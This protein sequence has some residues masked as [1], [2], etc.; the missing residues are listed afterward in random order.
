[1]ELV[2]C[3]LSIVCGEK[4]ILFSNFHLR[5]VNYV[6]HKLSINNKRVQFQLHMSLWRIFV[7][8]GMEERGYCASVERGAGSGDFE[9]GEQELLSEFF[10]Y[11]NSTKNRNFDGYFS[12]KNYFW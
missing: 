2:E 6:L 9:S 11:Q 10:K 12:E 5:R 1:M 4:Y 8:E 7:E 3:C